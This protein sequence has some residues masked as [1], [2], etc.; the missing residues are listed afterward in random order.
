ME[1]TGSSVPITG[2]PQDSAAPDI[3]RD[4]KSPCFSGR[5]DSWPLQPPTTLPQNAA[6]MR[7]PA[8][9]A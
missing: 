4:A 8:L 1:S 6:E 5:T 3:I 2:S 7:P 9:G